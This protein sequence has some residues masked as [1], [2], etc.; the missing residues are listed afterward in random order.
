MAKKL[1]VG[2]LSYETTKKQLE[3][4]F[5]EFDSV[6]SIDMVSDRRTGQF[7]GFAFVTLSSDEQTQEAVR[8][9]NG[10]KLLDREIVVNE[11]RATRDTSRQD[12]RGGFDRKRR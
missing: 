10:K 8:S 11:A 6:T 2:N 3:E 4:L 5:G 7:R 9:L 1:Y 12:K